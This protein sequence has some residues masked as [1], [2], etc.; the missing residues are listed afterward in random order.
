MFV[1]LYS[2]V[3]FRR[4]VVYSLGISMQTVM[5]SASKESFFSCFLLYMFFIS[6]FSFF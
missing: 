3:S 2:L 6:F 1:C 4:F 5:P